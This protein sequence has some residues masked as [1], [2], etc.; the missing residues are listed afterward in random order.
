MESADLLE[1]RDGRQT[2][3]SPHSD[4]FLILFFLASNKTDI[5]QEEESKQATEGNTRTTLSHKG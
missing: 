1:R 4:N 2:T 3:D 5:I